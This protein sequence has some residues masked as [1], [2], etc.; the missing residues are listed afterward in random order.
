MCA[1]GQVLTVVRCSRRLCFC[2]E[3]ILVGL[4]VTGMQSY[5]SVLCLLIL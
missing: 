4:V 1:Y 5:K 2:I 3:V